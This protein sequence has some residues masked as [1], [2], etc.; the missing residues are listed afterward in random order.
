MRLRSLVSS[1]FLVLLF[2]PVYPIFAISGFSSSLRSD[3]ILTL[4]FVVLF[5]LSRLVKIN[6][7]IKSRRFGL[8]L[9][10]MT[11]LFIFRSSNTFA[12]VMQFIIYI[13]LYFSFLL[14]RDT[15]LSEGDKL[16][17]ALVTLLIVDCIIHVFYHFTGYDSL[18]VSYL[19]GLGQNENDFYFGLFGTSKMPFQ[20]IL[21]VAALF[22]VIIA[23]KNKMNYKSLF[24]LLLC[25][26]AAITSE[27]RIGLFGLLFGI[28]ITVPSVKL[29]LLLIL[30]FLVMCAQGLV[31]K[32]ME[33]LFYQSGDL[34]NDPSLAMRLENLKLFLEWFSLDNILFGGGGFAILGFTNTYDSPGA[35]DIFYVRVLAEFGIPV[36][37][38]VCYFSFSRIAKALRNASKRFRQ[39]IVGWLAFLIIYSVFNEGILASRSG[40]LVFYV[41]G[42]I[43]ALAVKNSQKSTFKETLHY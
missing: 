39:L 23:S 29:G 18:S 30:T 3:H 32:K 43:F 42:M 41:T 21:Y 1:S 20:F 36:I 9:M 22:F 13:S 25:I 11:I 2:F 4:F 8:M 17:S 14:G 31:T 35:L 10:L 12:G 34:L 6:A 16:K 33:W 38:I 15:V 7:L 28:L 26:V 37:L 5:L 40:H 19:N 24:I 27:S